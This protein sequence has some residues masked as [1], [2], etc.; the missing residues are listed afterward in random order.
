MEV[1]ILQEGLPT[2]IQ[3]IAAVIV[4]VVVGVEEAPEVVVPRKM[5]SP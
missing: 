2:V 3:I 4:I 1:P 5:P